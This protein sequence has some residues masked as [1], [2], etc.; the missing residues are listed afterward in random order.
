MKGAATSTPHPLEAIPLD[1]VEASPRNP[2]RKLSEIAELA[3]SMRQYGLLQPV[4]VR[5]SGE[6]F[7]V[8]AGHRRVAAARELGWS[9]IPALVREVDLDDAYLLT[10]IENLQRSDLTPREEAGG[11]EVLIRERGWTTRQVAEAVKRSPAFVSKRLRVFEDPLLAPLV[12]TNDLSVSLAEEL[13]PLPKA[14]K[15][16]LAREAVERGWD[17]ARLRDAIRGR[18]GPKQR[19]RP[20]RITAQANALRK[21]LRDASPA[22]LTEAERRALGLLFQELA[23]VAR[24]PTEP[25][26][27]IF[28]PLPQVQSGRR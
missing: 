6:A 21:A 18:F 19:A 28:P 9:T 23:M 17:T 26:A 5:R 22:S 13:L 12:L 2:R 16:T 4:V 14:Q 15:S 20:A 1:R 25:R 27:V 8:I 3:A 24:A 7:Q 11:L 10:L